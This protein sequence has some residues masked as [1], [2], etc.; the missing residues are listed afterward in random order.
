MIHLDAERM[1]QFR[2]AVG[3]PAMNRLLRLGRTT[4]GPDTKAVAGLTEE[5]IRGIQVPALALYGEGS[6]FLATMHYLGENL[7]HCRTE[8][9]PSAKHRAPEENPEGFVAAMR[10]FLGSLRTR[11][12]RAMS[13]RSNQ[14]VILTGAAN[15][16]GRATALA[17]ASRGYR[18]G[19]I[20]RD[21]ERLEDVRRRIGASA[22]ASAADVA[23]AD[24][25]KSAVA[26][27]RARR[28]GR[29]T[30]SWRAQVSGG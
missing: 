13:E 1:L 4:C 8:V 18:L 11:R 23:D 9:I 3:L 27:D 16:I 14:V 29:P 26:A 30:C 24:A 19:L 6:P 7:P 15:G 20:D 25:M 10:S 5:L 21:T 17:L 28:S 22:A 2:Q 12:D